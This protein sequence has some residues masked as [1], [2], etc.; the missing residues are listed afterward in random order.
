VS[1][2]TA[3]SPV[4]PGAAAPLPTVTADTRRR[5][6]A[7]KRSWITK[8]L[9]VLV[10]VGLAIL[11]IYP[12]EWLV[13]AAFKPRGDTF[14]N[15]FLPATWAW[16]FTGEKLPEPFPQKLFNVAPV[17]RWMWNSIWISGLGSL[18]VTFASALVASSSASCSP[19]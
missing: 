11:F 19:R 15:R 13:A 12:L 7:P 8:T 18:L 16:N 14:D 5:R 1:D 3:P 2:V 9:L 17:A 10:L 4:A 6:L